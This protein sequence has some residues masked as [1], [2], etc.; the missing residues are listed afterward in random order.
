MPCINYYGCCQVT[1]H[2]QLQSGF[3]FCL[4]MTTGKS[5]SNDERISSDAAQYNAGWNQIVYNIRGNPRAQQ[6]VARGLW[7]LILSTKEIPLLKSIYIQYIF[8]IYPPLWKNKKWT[9]KNHRPCCC[10]VSLDSLQPQDRVSQSRELSRLNAD[11]DIF[12]YLTISSI[13]WRKREQTRKTI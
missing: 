3:L 12:L 9:F 6:G 13:I 2:D 5:R 11:E 10:C 7:I 1:Q 8:C 4:S